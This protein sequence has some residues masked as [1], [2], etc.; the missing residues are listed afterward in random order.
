MPRRSAPDRRERHVA[1]R[2]TRCA[3]PRRVEQ[4]VE[5]DRHS[6]SET[7]CRLG[8]R[9]SMELGKKRGS[10]ASR[11]D[12]P[13]RRQVVHVQ[14]R[15]YPQ[16]GPRQLEGRRHSRGREALHQEREGARATEGR[17]LLEPPYAA[18]GG[19]RAPCIVA[20]KM[21]PRAAPDREAPDPERTS[22]RRTRGSAARQHCAPSARSAVSDLCSGFT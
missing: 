20:S 11:G 6:G 22:R 17:H 8:A 21:P 13:D 10:E 5:L 7:R 15:H 1:P 18:A 14:H 4:Q 12:L 3:G 9:K 19:Q 16:G 2:I